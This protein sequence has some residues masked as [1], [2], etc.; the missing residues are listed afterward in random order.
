MANGTNDGPLQEDER[1]ELARLRQEVATL[2][3]QTPSARETTVEQ[4]SRPPRHGLRWT[5]V[6][7]L[8]VLVA[9]LAV[10]S[11]TTRFTRSQILDTDRYVST[12]APL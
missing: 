4:V 11:V 1:A 2:R 10:L 8:L 9:L 6:A 7:I 12:V 3:E 5:A